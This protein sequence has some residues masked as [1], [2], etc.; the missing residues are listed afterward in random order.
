M[1]GKRDKYQASVQS[2]ASRNRFYSRGSMSFWRF[3]YGAET[4][5]YKSA[6]MMRFL[7]CPQVIASA[8]AACFS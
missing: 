5:R 1:V 2:V 8:I 3:F 7:I 6:R 4:C